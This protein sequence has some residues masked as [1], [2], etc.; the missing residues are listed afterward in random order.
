[1]NAHLGSRRSFLYRLIAYS[2]TPWVGLLVLLRNFQT[3]EGRLLGLIGIIAGALALYLLFAR[4]RDPK[5]AIRFAL[6][7]LS[8]TRR[9]VLD[10]RPS[11]N[12]QNS[13]GHQDVLRGF[14][15]GK[16]PDVQIEERTDSGSSQAALVV[17]DAVLVYLHEP[18]GSPEDPHALEQILSAL[19]TPLR[20]EPLLFVVFGDVSRAHP[21][22]GALPGVHVIEKPL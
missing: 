1:M 2:L 4:L 7:P 3:V 9:L 13:L 18:S 11:T 10:W 19:R 15:V 14:L 12:T 8:T 5:S 16:L 21:L 20:E 22:A 6:R 17:G